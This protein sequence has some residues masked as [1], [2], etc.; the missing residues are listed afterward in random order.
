MKSSTAEVKSPSHPLISED[1]T[2]SPIILLHGAG[3]NSSIWMHQIGNFETFPVDLPGHGKTPDEAVH[4]IADYA[5]F[6]F[7]II[8]ER[9]LYGGIIVG[10]SMG[11]AIAQHL[12]NHYPGIVR[13]LVL[14]STGARLKVSSKIFE[15]IRTDY[16]DFINRISQWAFSRSRISFLQQEINLFKDILK[17]TS[18]DVTERDFRLCDAFDFTRDYEAGSI[19]IPVPTLIVVG[20]DDV[21]TPIEYSKYLHTRIPSSEMVI[22]E[23]AGHMVMLEQSSEFNALLLRFLTRI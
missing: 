17:E 15:L 4:S 16:D 22:I 10:H 7:R 9:G 11:G 6:V 13:G 23:D 12:V 3:C 20:A 14:T 1:R 8:A 18:P 5:D 2:L 21:L 19:N